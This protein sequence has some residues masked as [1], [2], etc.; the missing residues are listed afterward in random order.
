MMMIVHLSS[1]P[2]CQAVMRGVKKSLFL[3][4]EIPKRWEQEKEKSFEYFLQAL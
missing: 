2:H 1:F 3:C 4:D